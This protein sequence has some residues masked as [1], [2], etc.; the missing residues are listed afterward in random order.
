MEKN[1]LT[2]VLS[3]EIY[4]LRLRLVLANAGAYR[5]LRSMTDKR[6]EQEEKEEIFS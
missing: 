6:E 4:V 3:Y 1:F 2:K 5:C